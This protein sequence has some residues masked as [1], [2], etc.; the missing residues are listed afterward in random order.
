MTAFD[1]LAQAYIDTWNQTD[2][3]NRA[4]AVAALFATD[5]RYVDPMA[6]AEGQPGIAITIDAVQQQFPGFVFRLLGPVDGHHDQVRFR[7]EFGPA[8]EPAPIVGFDVATCNAAGRIQSVY[9]FLD[10]VPSAT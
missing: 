8:G 2:P 1:E 7:W 5:A 6:V 10:R 9:G 3:S 4:S